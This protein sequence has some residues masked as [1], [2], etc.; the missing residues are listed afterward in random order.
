VSEQKKESLQDKLSA[1]QKELTNVKADLREFAKSGRV[2]QR[3]SELGPTQRP[4]SFQRAVPVSTAPP[5]P[6]TRGAKP[7]H[8]TPE[9]GTGEQQGLR[10]RDERFVD[11]LSA[12]IQI[13][14]PLR[15]VRQR[16]RNKTLAVIIILVLVA[17]WVIGKFLS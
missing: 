2:P 12:S 9:A 15:S 7:V 16:Q 3:R 17:L 4:A 1:V 13:G 5:L 10:P 14:R 8:S 6:P 11:Y